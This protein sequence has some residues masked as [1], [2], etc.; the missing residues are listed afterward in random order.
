MAKRKTKSKV[1]VSP[2]GYA[3]IT[4]NFNNTLVTITNLSGDT[5][6]WSS[7]GKVGFKGSKKNTPYAASQAARDCAEQAVKRGVQEVAVRIKGLGSAREN[8]IRGLGELGLKVT[9]IQDCT[10]QPHNGCR[11]PKKRAL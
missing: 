5:I 8:A 6:A 9:R 4:V 10:P 3:C 7:A 11:P 1:Q 2:K